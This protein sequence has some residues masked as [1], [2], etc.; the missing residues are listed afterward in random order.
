MRFPLKDESLT[1]SRFA[2]MTLVGAAVVKA[3]RR[4]LNLPRRAL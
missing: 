2:A 1:A 3:S 4:N